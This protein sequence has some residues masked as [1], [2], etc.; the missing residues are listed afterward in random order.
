MRR[1][2]KVLVRV[3]VVLVVVLVVV[4]LA[5]VAARVVNHYRYPE[6]ALEYPEPRDAAAYPTALPGVAVEPIADGPVRGFHLRPDE[7]RHR[8][9][10]LVWGGSEGGP[11]FPHAELLARAGHEVLA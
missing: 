3:G 4:G 1:F 6:P 8:G 11:D 10:V 9:V 5:V 2:G 7:I